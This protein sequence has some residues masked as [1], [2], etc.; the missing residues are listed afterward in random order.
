[1]PTDEVNNAEEVTDETT[2][3]E[4]T[5]TEETTES[6]GSGDDTES[7]GGS[8]GS[9][10]NGTE[11]SKPDI[12][13]MVDKILLKGLQA[14][15]DALTEKDPDKIY[16]CTDTK[17][18]YV[19]E[20][21]YTQAYRVLPTKPANP[22]V[23]VLYYLEDTSTIEAYVNG[24]WKV[25][26]R[27]TV[28]SIDENSTDDQI[29]TA[30]AVYKLI[31]DK[32]G[33]GAV[34]DIKL[35]DDVDAE[36]G[37]FIVTKNDQ[38]TEIELKGVV[39]NP[40]YVPE[41]RKITLPV[42]GGTD[43]VIELGK[44]IFLDPTKDNKYNSTTKEIDLYLT[45]DQ[46]L[47]IPVGD[48]IHEYE[49]DDTNKTITVTVDNVNGKIAAEAKISKAPYNILTVNDDGLMVSDEQIYNDMKAIADAISWGSF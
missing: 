36:P 16:F 24:D 39:V 13:A 21:L 6:S 31:T 7:I 43:V 47:H 18:I 34:T 19:G 27:E 41:T 17:V 25:I 28:T 4:D 5:S 10:S 9:E 49:G 48:M 8:E 38:P 23:G 2:S 46:E 33:S 29:P 40:T 30:A 20:D 22:A 12:P 37:K 1:M 45:S 26:A 15:Y 14:S 11:G 3:T 32:A 44:D 35:P 42:V